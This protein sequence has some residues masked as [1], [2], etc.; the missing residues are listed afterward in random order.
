M[1]PQ[2]K[3][4]LAM[5]IGDEFDP[6]SIYAYQ[7]AD[8]AATCGIDKKLISRNARPKQVIMMSFFFLFYC[9][10]FFTQDIY[11]EKINEEHM[12]KVIEELQRKRQSYFKEREDS[13]DEKV[14]EYVIDNMAD[15]DKLAD[16]IYKNIK[17]GFDKLPVDFIY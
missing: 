3:Q 8:F 11:I 7:L 13:Y 10:F 2:F 5:A 9:L 12:I 14:D 1:Y 15:I 6:N 16:A 4:S 17:V